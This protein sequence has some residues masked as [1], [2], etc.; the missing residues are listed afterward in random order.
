[1]SYRRDI[2][3]MTGTLETSGT[4]GDQDL[5]KVS[6]DGFEQAEPA[7]KEGAIF[8]DDI[9]Q[10]YAQTG[11][12]NPH[13]TIAAI[14]STD[15]LVDGREDLP[16][17]H[18]G[19]EDPVTPDLDNLDPNNIP[20]GTNR[21]GSMAPSQDMVTYMPGTAAPLDFDPNAEGE[22][23]RAV[24][25]GEEIP[26]GSPGRATDAVAGPNT[27]V[28]DDGEIVVDT[29]GDDVTE[30]ATST[31]DAP[32]SEA[33]VAGNADTTGTAEGSGTT[34]VNVEGDASV[35]V[36]GDVE[37]SETSDDSSSEDGAERPNVSDKKA[38]WVDYAEAQGIDTEGLTKD[39]II[40][41]VDAAEQG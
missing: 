15:E 27:E 18:R 28:T 19:T 30:T 37:V 13:E 23:Q 40:E 36:E 5:R 12:A 14:Q 38:D 33:S 2:G 16:E 17:G 11:A 29:S 25:A 24:V 7:N 6:P 26:M 22:P 20:G 34:D 32:A 10:A 21:R 9:A 1:M 35:K 31:D 4:G 3:P 39:E 41:A 8:E